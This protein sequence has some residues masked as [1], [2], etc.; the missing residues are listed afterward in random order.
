MAADY[1]V[2]NGGDDQLDGLVPATAWATLGHA[3]GSAVQIT[4]DAR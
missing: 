1:W 3:E 2:K 4:A